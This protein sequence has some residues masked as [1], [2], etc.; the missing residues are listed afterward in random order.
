MDEADRLSDRVAIIDYGKLLV[1]DS[2]KNLKKSIGE[3]DMLEVSFYDSAS[4]DQLNIIEQLSAMDC[5]ASFEDAILKAQ[6]RNIIKKLPDITKILETYG[7]R[8]RNMTIRENTLEDVFIHLTG[9][10]LRS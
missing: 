10:K 4:L 9:R 5:T 1:I 6:S 8:I 7:V 2:P 3:G